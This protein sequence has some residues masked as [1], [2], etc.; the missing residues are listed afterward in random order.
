M[1]YGF[2]GGNATSFLWFV[3]RPLLK[4]YHLGKTLSYEEAA[5]IIGKHFSHVKDK[6]INTLQLKGQSEGEQNEFHKQLIEASINQ[7]IVELKPIPFTKAVDYGSNKRYVKYFAIPLS[8]IILVLIIYPAMI[9]KST[10]RL[11][12]HDTFYEAPMPFSFL[13]QNKNMEAIKDEDFPIQLKVK[14]SELPAEV[15]VEVDGKPFRMSANSK[16]DF[17]YTLKNLRKNVEFRF[18]AN[19]FKSK[20]YML[21]VYPKPFMRKFEV[22]LVYPAY[23]N[24]KNETLQNTGD[25]TVPE[26]TQVQ[27]K[28]YTEN[29][30]TID[31]LFNGKKT[32]A[33]RSGEGEFIFNNKFTKDESYTLIARNQFIRKPDSMNYAVNVVTDAYPSISVVEDVDSEAIKNIY[34]TG[35]VTDDYGFSRLNFNYR[36]VK[37]EDSAKIV[38]PMKMQGI[39]IST[40]QLLQSFY[41]FFDA[42]ALNIRPGDEVEYYFEVWDNDGVNGAKSARSEKFYFK[43]P[44]DKEIEDKADANNEDMKDKMEQAIKESQQLQKQMQDARVR[45]NDKKNLDF[46]DKKFIEDIL[47]KQKDLQEKIEDINTQYKESVK[48]QTEFKEMDQ[49]ILEKHQQLQEMFDKIMD[50]EMKKLFDEMKKLLEQKNADQLQN[51]LED[52]KFDQKEVQKELDRMM[53]LFKQVEMEQ[54]MKE[55]TDKLDK[56][57]EEQQKLAEENDKGKTSNEELKKKQ[58]ELNK[59]FD[60]VKEDMKELEKKNEELE[61]KKELGDTKEEQKNA[62]EQMKQSK[63]NLE[64]KQNKKASQNQKKAADEMKKMSAKMKEM[65]EAEEEKDM[66]LDYQALRQIM[67][68]LVYTS[69]QQ[70]AL[71]NEFKTVTSYNPQ[72]VE[73]AQRQRK[74]KDDAKMIEDSLASLSKRVP[75]ISSMVNK[76]VGKINLNMQKSLDDLAARRTP[77]ARNHQQFTMTSMNNLAVMLSEIMKQMQAQMKESQKKKDGKPGKKPGK[78][79]G[80]KP[81]EGKPKM[82]GIKA[83]QQQLNQQIKELKDG[84]PGTQGQMSKQLAEMAAKQEAI[85]RELQRLQDENA[86]EGGKPSKELKDIQNLMDKTEEDLVNKNLSTEMMKRQEEIMVRMLESEKAEK[87][88]EE[89]E[90]RESKTANNGKNQSPPSLEKYLQMKQKETELLNTIPPNLTPY[91][92]QKVKEYFESIR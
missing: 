69:F 12:N 79:P 9:V 86:K 80:S 65:S 35:Q 61:D 43:A 18:E 87:Q 48:Q 42:S 14:G 37:S 36:F 70:E 90:K 88:Q 34:F 21:T 24:K 19:G 71:M 20:P 72:Y 76:E 27:W 52:S 13:L 56:L 29:T 82:S 68:N 5:Q 78:K 49:K 38:M 84:K 30:E 89:D 63:E 31:L 85:R 46:Q 55:T 3:A 47:K 6:L 64:S 44:S 1:F 33:T 91:Y 45:L 11:V 50:P 2:V 81:G 15:Y 23:I 41:H 77:E 62:E 67:D 26:G 60:E 66:G 16:N 59:K 7:R 73:L 39:A 40:N 8:I 10:E 28:F 51:K 17:V 74:L 53:E 54:K 75:D 25:L 4:L 57:A 83:M 32:S 58:D 22:K 92:R